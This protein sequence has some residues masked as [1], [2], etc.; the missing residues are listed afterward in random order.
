MFVHVII[1]VSQK[2]SNLIIASRCHLSFH[3]ASSFLFEVIFTY[4]D[5]FFEL[6]S[7]ISVISVTSLIIWLVLSVFGHFSG[8]QGAFRTTT[9][10]SC[11]C[12]AESHLNTREKCL[13]VKN[14]FR[15]AVHLLMMDNG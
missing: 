11:C 2:S 9:I 8:S 14:S 6:I 5:H 12:F 13:Q 15:D 3:F 10:V 4:F 7:V 1:R